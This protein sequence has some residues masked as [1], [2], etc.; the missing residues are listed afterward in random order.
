MA[1]TEYDHRMVM[2]AGCR[3]LVPAVGSHGQRPRLRQQILSR[4]LGRSFLIG[5]RY[6]N[7]FYGECLRLEI[8]GQS[9][10]AS[11]GMTLEGVPAGARV[12]FDALMRFM[13]RRAPGR[14]EYAT[15]RREADIPE[16]TSGLRNGVTDGAPITAVIRNTDARPHDYDALRTV[17]RPGHADYSAWL[18]YG[19]IPTA[20]ESLRA[21][22][23]RRCAW[24]AGDACSCLKVRA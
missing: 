22:G 13:Q 6:M 24:P 1:E 19:S 5:G 11:I 7:G 3:G 9:H 2:A 18:R 15:A 16:F 21:H 8:F 17:P 20:A 4:L 14:G 10:A 12:D 23:Q